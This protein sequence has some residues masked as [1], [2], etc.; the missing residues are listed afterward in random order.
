MTHAITKGRTLGTKG[1]VQLALMLALTV[2][3]MRFSI[4]LPFVNISLTYLP[5][6]L[7]GM[8]FGPVAGA[9]VG[10][11]SNE[12]DALMRGFG[13]N[14]LYSLIP[15]L[16]GLLYG[17]L[18]HDR[19]PTRRQISLVQGGIDVF[20]HILANTLLLYLFYNKGAFGALPLRILKNVMFFP[21]EVF[22]LIKLSDYRSVFTRLT[23]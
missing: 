17:L 14:P 1:L 22:T 21:I 12:L 6:A 5:I 4:N 18:L 11:L 2:L 15:M 19:L 20:L 7:T 13:F 23:R 10:F 16:K 3:L 8:L 9:A